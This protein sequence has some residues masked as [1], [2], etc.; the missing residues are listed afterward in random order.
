[1]TIVYLAILWCLG[2]VTV[3]LTGDA[4][5]FIW[6][7]G[8]GLSAVITVLFRDRRGA[9]MTALYF[10]VFFAGAWRADAA[11]INVNVNELANFGNDSEVT[12]TGTVGEPPRVRDDS[13]DL[14]ISVQTVQSAESGGQ[15]VEG[16]ILVEAPRFPLYAYGDRIRVTGTL[17]HVENWG[18]F[19]YRQYLARQGIYRQIRGGRVVRLES[20]AGNAFYQTVYALRARAQAVVETMVPEPQSS[21][22][23]G[24][25]LGDESGMPQALSDD[26][27]ATG[28]T[29]IIAIS[30]FNIAILAGALLR[31]GRGL[32]GLRRSAWGALAGISVYTIL[33]GADA[34]V[35]RAA[36]MGSLYIFS[37]RLLGRPTFAPAGLFVAA[38]LMTLA[39]PHVLWDI[40]F[41]LSFAAT[42]GLMLFVEP[43][44]VRLHDGLA[45]FVPG[46]RL[47]RLMPLLTDVIIVTFAAQLMS[48]PLLAYHFGEVSVASAVANLLIL[49]AQPGVMLWGGAATIAGLVSPL[50]GQPIAWV[51]WLFLSYTA[52][53]GAGAASFCRSRRTNKRHDCSPLLCCVVGGLLAGAPATRTTPCPAGTGTRASGARRARF[54]IFVADADHILA[55]HAARR[56]PARGVSRRGPG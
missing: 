23:S 16:K 53:G 49:P 3:S 14:T 10:L 47:T 2:I 22:L 48:L 26:F 13:V 45:R 43:L 11:F 19:D 7:A 33:V 29:H 51:A 38:W 36:F 56:Q 15:R 30:G 44:S 4:P 46:E 32:V 27:R 52:G 31:G 54:A 9:R 5:G 37:N 21:L 50:L 6:I 8:G 20:G 28:M 1:M 25:L 41:Q 24:I 39:N 40:G 42:L 35:V 55:A 17:D 12:V 18:D 34:A